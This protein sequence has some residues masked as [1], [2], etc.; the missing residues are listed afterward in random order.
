S[1]ACNAT[2]LLL[3]CQVFAEPMKAQRSG[4]IVNVGSVAGVVGPDFRIYGGTGTGSPVDY[5]FAKGGMLAMTLYLATYLAP[6][7]V[8]VNVLSPG[9]VY[10]GRQTPEFLA[11]YCDRV[12]LRR[13]AV[14]ND[15]KGAVVFLASDAA[16]YVTGQ[17]LLVDGGLTAW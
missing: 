6:Y 2:G 3:A 1:M 4:S 9:G 7:D 8:R 11:A 14:A 12:P 16:A 5:A 10:S 13:M 17:N 15:L